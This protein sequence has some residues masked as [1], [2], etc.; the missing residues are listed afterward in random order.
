MVELVVSPARQTIVLY[1]QF[2]S[3]VRRIEV[4]LIYV[5]VVYG[6][7]NLAV[8]LAASDSTR[9]R[10]LKIAECQ[11]TIYSRL[12]TVLLRYFRLFM[13]VACSG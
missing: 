2:L 8:H 1:A 4:E 13:G 3:F 9:R 12:P 11:E 10:R 6:L 5:L 7:A